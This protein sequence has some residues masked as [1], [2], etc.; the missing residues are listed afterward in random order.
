MAIGL[1]CARW[2]SR[3]VQGA[4]F[5]QASM[6]VPDDHDAVAE[7]IKELYADWDTQKLS[8]HDSSPLDES[9]VRYTSASKEKDDDALRA[10]SEPTP[11]NISTDDFCKSPQQQSVYR[12]PDC[13]VLHDVRDTGLDKALSQEMQEKALIL[14]EK[15]ERFGVS[16]TVVAIKRGPVVMLYE[17]QPHIDTKISKI[18]A[19]EDDLRLHCKH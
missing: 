5:E 10:T 18:I 14:Q 13:T 9:F 4:T 8:V 17:Y 12:L 16:G 11:Q 7:K 3:F 15:L 6:T 19:L 1:R 2:I